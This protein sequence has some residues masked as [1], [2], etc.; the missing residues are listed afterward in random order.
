MGEI[1]PPEDFNL[2]EAIN[3]LSLDVTIKDRKLN[4]LKKLNKPDKI[5]LNK[6]DYSQNYENHVMKLNKAIFNILAKIKLKKTPMENSD[7]L[8]KLLNFIIR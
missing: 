4:K 8:N 5:L 6:I 1:K 2:Q 3:N 7:N